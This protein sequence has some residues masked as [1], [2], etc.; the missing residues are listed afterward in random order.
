MNIIDHGTWVGY[1]PA[2]TDGLP[3]WVPLTALFAKRESDGRDWYTYLDSTTRPPADHVVFTAIWNAGLNS[4]VVGAATYDST[5]IFPA[6]QLLQEIT[7]YAGTDPQA[8]L[9][10][11]LYDP[12]TGT[13]TDPPLPSNPLQSL[14]DRVAA[15]EAKQGGQ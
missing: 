5:L 14:L 9:G 15:L 4:Y 8:D 10:G 11:K 12:A 13:F 2:S 6:G 3:T 1:R 7:D